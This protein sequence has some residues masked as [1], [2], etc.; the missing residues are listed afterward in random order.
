MGYCWQ[1][2]ALDGLN[3]G[4]LDVLVSVQCS[5]ALRNG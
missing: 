4:E 1:G 5:V 2:R 3:L